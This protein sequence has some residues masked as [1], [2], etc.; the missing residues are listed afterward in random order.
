MSKINF[1]QV[2]KS[3]ETGEVI[4]DPPM[5][6]TCERCGRQNIM[7]ETVQDLTLKLIAVRAL[8]NIKEDDRTK[9]EEKY[10]RGKLAERIMES[11]DAVDLSAEEISMLKDLIGNSFAP[12]IVFKSF[13]MLDPKKE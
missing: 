11:K 13:E 3:I 10:K 6:F 1:T 8:L 7:V 4:K 2:F 5:I 12:Q 9:A